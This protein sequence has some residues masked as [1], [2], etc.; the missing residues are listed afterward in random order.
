LNSEEFRETFLRNDR[1]GPTKAEKAGRW[2]TTTPGMETREEE[3]CSRVLQRQER[4]TRPGQCDR[5]GEKGKPE[6]LRKPGV[7]SERAGG[8]R[9]EEHNFGRPRS[10]ARRYRKKRTPHT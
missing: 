3:I 4:P 1:E 5:P 2:R 9:P 8:E 10:R 6:A 7:T